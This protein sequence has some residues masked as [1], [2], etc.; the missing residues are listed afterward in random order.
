V[1]VVCALCGLLGGDEH[2]ADAVARDCVYTQNTDPARRCRERASR[3]RVANHAL[4]PFGLRLSG[5][6]QTVVATLRGF[7]T[8]DSNSSSASALATIPV[9]QVVHAATVTPNERRERSDARGIIDV[10]VGGP[11]T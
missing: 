3:V 2:W 1:Q 11:S 7:F 10:N 4:K 8:R 5:R 9:E 6:V